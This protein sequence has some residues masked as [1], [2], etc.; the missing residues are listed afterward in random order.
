VLQRVARY[1]GISQLQLRRESGLND[2]E[3]SRDCKFLARSGLVK[4]NPSKADRRVRV[5]TP[6]NRGKKIWE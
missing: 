4:I 6:T 2:Y 5:L 3:I 1:P